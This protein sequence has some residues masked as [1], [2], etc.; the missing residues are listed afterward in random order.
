[1]SALSRVDLILGSM[2]DPINVQVRSEEEMEAFAHN[3]LSFLCVEDRKK[4][5]ETVLAG[6]LSELCFPGSP[7]HLACKKFHQSEDKEGLS[8]SVFENVGLPTYEDLPAEVQA[9]FLR[10]VVNFVLSKDED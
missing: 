8:S 5:I 6:Y 4:I 7:C 3:G 2:F 10:E 1:M 9:Q